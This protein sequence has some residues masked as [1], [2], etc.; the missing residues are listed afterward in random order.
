M[1]NQNLDLKDLPAKLL[2][3]IY[4]I[5][6]SHVIVAVVIET[7]K[8]IICIHM[9]ACLLCVCLLVYVIHTRGVV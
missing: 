4:T 8:Y 6:H 1:H 9:Y 7:V 2:Q 3:L 5:V